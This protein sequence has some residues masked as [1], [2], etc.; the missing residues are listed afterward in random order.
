MKMSDKT[1]AI[2]FLIGTL[3]LAFLAT[4]MFPD[5]AGLP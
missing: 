3:C 1:L 4:I 2:T 5:L